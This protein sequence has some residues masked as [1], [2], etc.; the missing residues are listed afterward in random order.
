MDAASRSNA[1]RD[2]QPPTEPQGEN[3]RGHD[4]LRTE[5][6]SMAAE[7]HAIG[8]DTVRRQLD[9]LTLLQ[10]TEERMAAKAEAEGDI[11]RARMFRTA[12][13]E[14]A[15]HAAAI[16]EDARQAAVTAMSLAPKAP[17]L[18]RRGH[19][20][21]LSRPAVRRRSASGGATSRG[22]PDLAGDDPPGHRPP[23]REGAVA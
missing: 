21:V 4:D 10:D 5:W 3:P 12:A 2:P 16:R 6:D 14:T 18:P 22:D 11:R 7:L 9:Q 8:D 1:D 13:R 15:R 20:G 17:R 23:L 19:V